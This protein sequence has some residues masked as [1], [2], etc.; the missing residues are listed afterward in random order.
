MTFFYSIIPLKRAAWF[1]NGNSSVLAKASIAMLATMSYI[2]VSLM[3]V[4]L[5]L[6]GR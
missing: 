2:V 6:K 5:F 3:R 1:S 4:R